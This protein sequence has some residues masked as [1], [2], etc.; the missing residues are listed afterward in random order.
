[1]VSAFN[2][3]IVIS[4]FWK[5]LTLAIRRFGF[6]PQKQPRTS[7]TQT[8]CVP[9]MLVHPAKKKVLLQIPRAMKWEALYFSCLYYWKVNNIQHVACET[10]WP[11][12]LSCNNRFSKLLWTSMF[13]FPY[14]MITNCNTAVWTFHDWFWRIRTRPNVQ[15]ASCPLPTILSS[16]KPP[17]LCDADCFHAYEIKTFSP[18]ITEYKGSGR[19][20]RRFLSYNKMKSILSFY[21]NLLLKLSLS[22]SIL[23]T[24]HFLNIVSVR[25]RPPLSAHSRKRRTSDKR[26]T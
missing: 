22:Q 2:I 1:M 12:R 20:T 17:L 10:N 21:V 19:K 14:F 11:Q 5:R 6:W 23:M 3:N 18:P 7:F 26:L 24:I 15:Q 25:W 4:E 16:V 13:R 8:C 9:Y